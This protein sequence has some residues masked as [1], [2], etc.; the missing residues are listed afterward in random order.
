[1]IFGFLTAFLGKINFYLGLI[2]AWV[3]YLFLSYIV[4]VV[5][6]LSKIPGIFIKF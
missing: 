6:T 2:P 3:C 4:W 1:M 5:E